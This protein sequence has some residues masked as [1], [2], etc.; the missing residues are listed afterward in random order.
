MMGKNQP[1]ATL[2][3]FGDAMINIWEILA[4]MGM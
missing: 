4:R 2:V 1:M 3:K